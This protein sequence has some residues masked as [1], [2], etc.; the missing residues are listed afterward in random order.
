MCPVRE[1]ILSFHPMRAYKPFCANSEKE[2]RSLS[3]FRRCPDPATV[4]LDDPM[5]RL[6]GRLLYR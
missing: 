5:G 4:P 2:S 1:L 6:R 3:C